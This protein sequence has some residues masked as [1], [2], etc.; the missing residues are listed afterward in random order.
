MK[1]HS[2]ED[3]DSLRQHLK[4]QFQNRDQKEIPPEEL[5]S[6]VFKTIDRIQLF[7]DMFELFTVDFAN[8]EM[9]MIDL[10][11]KRDDALQP[12]AADPEEA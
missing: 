9:K 2:Y 4:R 6:Q 1:D 3:S 11:T 8:S 7:T 10:M 5:K 12:P